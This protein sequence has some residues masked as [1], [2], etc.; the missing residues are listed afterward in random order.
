MSCL[1]TLTGGPS[2]Q[3]LASSASFVAG[4]KL[5]LKTRVHAGGRAACNV[6][7][8]RA[9]SADSVEEPESPEETFEV[10]PRLEPGLRTGGRFV[11][12][13]GRPQP[14]GSHRPANAWFLGPSA[15]G[16]DPGQTQA[17]NKSKEKTR[18]FKLQSV[19]VGLQKRKS[20]LPSR[21]RGG[22]PSQKM[23][24]GFKY[25]HPWDF[26][27]Y[28]S[29]GSSSD[30]LELGPW[31]SIGAVT[32]AEMES[33]VLT[34]GV[35]IE[36]KGGIS[37][38]LNTSLQIT[39]L[40][41]TSFRFR[42]APLGNRDTY[43]HDYH[44]AVPIAD[45]LS[46]AVFPQP[47]AVAS[48]AK[49]EPTD[50]GWAVDTGAM[51]VLIRQSQLAIDVLQ[52][53]K[54]IV[55][56]SGRG[57]RIGNQGHSAAAAFR[58]RADSYCFGFGQKSGLQLDKNREAMTFFNY[59][60]FAY[61]FDDPSLPLYISVPLLIETNAGREGADS[62]YAYGIF[63]DNPAQTFMNL[64]QDE[65]MS[66]VSDA[67]FLGGLYGELNYYFFLGTREGLV[68]D[69]V[70]QYT[71]L[72]GRAPLP[73]R[74]ALG[75]HQGCYGYKNEGLIRQVADAYRSKKIPCDGIHIDVD[76]QEDHR[77]FTVSESFTKE[78]FEFFQLLLADGF[79]CSTNITSKITTP[80][81]G[82]PALESGLQ[83]EIPEL[84]KVDG[85]PKR[86]VFVE[87]PDGA[88]TA[89]GNLFV[90]GQSYGLD[91]DAGSLLSFGHYPDLSLPSARKWWGQ[92]YKEL[93]NYGLAMVWQDMM[94]PA[95]VG[96]MKTLPFHIQQYDYGR[97]SE[98]VKLHN[99]WG[100]NMVQGT[101]EG[102]QRIYK[103]SKRVGNDEKV[104][105]PLHVQGR[106]F[107]V[108]RGGY[109]GSQRYAA[110]WTGDNISMWENYA[111][112]VPMVLNLG[113]SGMPITG[114]DVGGYGNGDFP[115]TAT[116]TSGMCPS[117]LLV[118]W[119]AAAAFFPW[120]RNHYSGYTKLFQEPWA[121]GEAVESSCR[122]YIELRYQMLQL[123]YDLA[124]E[125]TR[126]GSPM[127]RPLFWHFPRDPEAYTC[128]SDQFLVGP[129]VL[130]APVMKKNTS[131]RSVYLPTDPSLPHPTVWYQFHGLGRPLSAPLQGG[132]SHNI[133]APVEPQGES[134]NVFHTV[135][136]FVREGAVVPFRQV[137][138]YVGHKK[139]NPLTLHV[140][141][142]STAHGHEST[143]TLY[144]DDG[145]SLAY[146]ELQG[147]SEEQQV[148]RLSRVSASSHAGRNGSSSTRTLRVKWDVLH[149]GFGADN[150]DASEVYFP[151]GHMFVRVH[152]VRATP[153]PEVKLDGTAAAFVA[154]E[155]E[156]IDVRV[157]YPAKELTVTGTW[158]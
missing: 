5:Q 68:P 74:W 63:L 136:V 4:K 3:N 83:H 29:S 148:Y 118:R 1:H 107:I 141:P 77:P 101:F 78:P 16:R 138:Q 32:S 27:P 7:H 91:R 37:A 143:H 157:P 119:T 38:P 146:Q 110:F 128:S 49:L 19:Q 59:D 104:P 24:T 112:S 103:D 85:K 48:D 106:P 97:S 79:K 100:H 94:D 62:A 113:L 31:A 72:T 55:S 46:T 90:G 52:G 93:Y 95:M 39:F 92:Q 71:D 13:D 76:I 126:A 130:V 158:A 137:E 142:S 41:K 86:G 67:Y 151:D 154:N 64:S 152:G 50:D 53:D 42:Y 131:Q 36:N 129:Y 70:R 139:Y 45:P 108:A 115:G 56:D 89:D 140:Y 40:T 147:S 60:N 111:M 26:N 54:L 98:H 33:G 135:P 14:T 102:L 96:P 109:A 35:N 149:D 28:S 47:D 61:N 34:L 87:D 11:G 6:V 21:S 43:N 125:H 15:N 114:P 122:A 82:Y 8:A 155:V 153:A 58:A 73:P 22:P 150:C 12:A 66:G 30:P 10:T 116:L 20:N 9:S 65:S 124:H 99:A 156:G 17:E 18:D 25:V 2:L 144:Q 133:D 44:Y 75:Y 105:V 88:Y 117:D 121:Y 145:E 69:V 80:G 132:Q 81:K 51:K 127:M 23:S 57:V 120:F 84:P 123:W 134:G